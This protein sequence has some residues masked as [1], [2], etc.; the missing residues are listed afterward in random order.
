MNIKGLLLLLLPLGV[1]AQ[2]V[3]GTDY[4]L[5]KTA[6]R[7]TVKVEK[8]QYTPGRL[9]PYAHRFLRTDV[10]QDPTTSYRLI[11]I[12]MMPYAVPDTSRHFTLIT[13]KKHSVN[14]VCRADNG[15][16]LA[17]NADA[18]ATP[19][20]S[21]RFTP[22]PKPARPN[23]HDFMTEDILNAGSNAKMAELTAQE[24]YDIRDSRNQLNRGEA[25]F[26]PK[27]GTQM[28]IMLGNLDKQ[29]AALS[30][31]FTGTTEKD[32]TWTN[33]DFV[34][35]REGQQVLFRLSQW[36]GLVDADDLSGEPYLVTVN[37][38]HTIAQ[39][40][41][42]PEGQKEDKND[43][44]L[45]VSQPSKIKVS[46]AHG[47]QVIGSYE[48]SAPQFG[49]VESLSGELFGKKQSAKLILDP[50]TGSVKSIEAIMN[51]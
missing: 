47:Q 37:D 1:S 20:P 43:I 8:T 35:T 38:K 2:S 26:M 16:L 32:T 42:T 12:D 45:R 14:K 7:F 29:E 44:G 28:A 30:S 10:K 34:P 49:T 11:G 22:G 27:D 33:I 48:V 25:D 24:I 51:N 6:L 46:I 21:P 9:A 39:P 31:L 17:I 36:L 23:P 41:P 4:Y 40:Q 15:Q 19:T 5:P 13:D 18:S 50:L 3:E